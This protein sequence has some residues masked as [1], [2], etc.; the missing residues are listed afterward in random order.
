MPAFA[1][2]HVDSV[3]TRFSRQYPLGSALVQDLLFPR[4]SV[5]KETGVFFRYNKGDQARIPYTKRQIRSESRTVDWRVD[6]D[7]YSC[8]EYALNDL[9]DDREYPQAD[10]PLNLQRDTIENLQRLM[11][12]DREK[13]VHG[14]ATD[15]AV[16][17]KNVTLAGTNQWRDAGASGATATPLADFEARAEAI[18]ADTGVRPNTAIFGMQAWLA[19]SKVTEIINRI[20]TPGGNWGSATITTDQART[21]LAPYGITTVRVADQI[22][23]T[24]GFGAADSFS[25]IWSD[26]VGLYYITPSPGIKKVSFG[27]AFWARSWQVRR[28]RDEKKHSDWFEPSCVVDEKVIAADVAALIIDVSDGS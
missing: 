25:D 26:E 20:V 8:E 13:R 14:L 27:Y 4:V 19:F 6:T 18:R 7:T 10:S 9:I 24:A 3:L 17:T 1:S 21:L 23:N 11:I 12:L 16:I 5:R 22:E 28:A 2:T 15:A